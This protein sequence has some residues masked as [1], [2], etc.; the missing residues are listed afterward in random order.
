MNESVWA[1]NPWEVSVPINQELRAQ[2]KES[3]NLLRKKIFQLL[4][5]QPE[6]GFDGK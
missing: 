2:G 1:Q 6:S 5:Q 4:L 3:T